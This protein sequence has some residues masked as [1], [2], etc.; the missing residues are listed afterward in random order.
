MQAETHVGEVCLLC[1]WSESA[2]RRSRA[3][4]VLQGVKMDL[5]SRPGVRAVLGV[6]CLLGLFGH[7]ALS[8]VLQR[9]CNDKP[10]I[11]ES[12]SALSLSRRGDLAL[13]EGGKRDRSLA[14][15]GVLCA[16]W[17]E[18]DPHRT[19]LSWAIFGPGAFVGLQQETRA[20]SLL[21]PRCLQSRWL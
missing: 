13:Q 1:P 5:L 6:C 10:I 17:K 7:S 15:E 12:L 18:R 11:G 2:L 20:E 14:R 8:F 4:Q 19:A 16:R 9:G 21:V 3:D